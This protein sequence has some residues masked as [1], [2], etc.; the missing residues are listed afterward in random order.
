MHIT[1]RYV[2]CVPALLSSA[3]KSS[4]KHTRIWL[5]TLVPSPKRHSKLLDPRFRFAMW[6]LHRL[7]SAEA[8]PYPYHMLINSPIKLLIIKTFLFPPFTPFRLN[9]PYDHLGRPSPVGKDQ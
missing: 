6:G 4:L 8:D 1:K 5:K 7:Y 2:S 3:R 9:L